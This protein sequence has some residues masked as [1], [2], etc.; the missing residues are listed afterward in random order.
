M[1]KVTK[2]TRI[3]RLEAGQGNAH[4]G[5]EISLWDIDATG[6]R[7]GDRVEV[8]IRRLKTTDGKVREQRVVKF[9]R[10][11]PRYE[12]KQEGSIFVGYLG[13]FPCVL[14]SKRETVV[15]MLADRFMG[16]QQRGEI[17]SFP[18]GR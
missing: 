18:K 11:A 17:V 16:D 13:G 12:I 7:E 15:R 3:K 1:Q 10:P 2:Q 5:I 9:P 14:A 4:V 8:Q 6:F